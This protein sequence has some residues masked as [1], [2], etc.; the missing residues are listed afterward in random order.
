MGARPAG[1]GAYTAAADDINALYWNPG[2]LSFL[3]KPELGF[4]HTE[5]YG[6]ARLETLGYAHPTRLGTFGAS[7]SYLGQG[8]IERRDSQGLKAGDYSASDRLF[9]L[10][11]AHPI[12]RFGL[13]VNAKFLQQQIAE[14]TVSGFAADLGA[15]YRPV[16]SLRLGV[17]VLNLGPGMRWQSGDSQL[18]LTLTG[19][20]AYSIIPQFMLAAD[21][22]H[23]FLEKKL[24]LGLGFEAE[25]Y[26]GFLL[27]A[28]YLAANGSTAAGSSVPALSRFTAGFGL[29][30]R[31]Y[32]VDYSFAP[33]GHIGNAQR[34]SLGYRF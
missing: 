23:R 31:D 1:L 2:G 17:S 27:R 30:L 3:S 34:L 12:G 9:V 18:P 29:R 28:S 14:T 8:R 21:V 16:R 32:S 13:G 10:G 11:Y 5:L 4:T 7:T 15:A 19:G 33:A 25:V 6:E 24:S 22:R 26:R 20:A